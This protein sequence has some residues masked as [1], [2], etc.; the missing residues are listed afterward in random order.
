MWTNIFL[1]RLKC[2]GSSSTIGKHQATTF[3]KISV[4]TTFPSAATTHQ[5]ASSLMMSSS[6]W[7]DSFRW[8]GNCQSF[9][10]MWVIKQ[11]EHSKGNVKINRLYPT[12][13]NFH[14]TEL[15]HSSLLCRLTQNGSTSSSSL[16]SSIK[17]EHWTS[18]MSYSNTIVI[19]VSVCPSP[20]TASS[21][22]HACVKK[23]SSSSS[24]SHIWKPNPALL[25]SFITVNLYTCIHPIM[26]LT[27]WLQYPLRLVEPQPHQQHCIN[28]SK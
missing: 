2:S 26:V 16:S 10:M 22:D 5:L 17:T 9:K 28:S 21:H 1:S 14:P 20:F 13:E 6:T 25:L 4:T 15:F 11:A 18:T 7:D 3:C 27:N 8:D 19:L 12:L 23:A 24:W